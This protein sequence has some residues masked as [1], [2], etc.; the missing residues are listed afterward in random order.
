MGGR[1]ELGSGARDC[2]GDA[3]SG[4]SDGGS[5]IPM[6]GKPRGRS[7]GG[8]SPPRADAPTSAAA[9]LGGPP[10]D[11]V[12]R[13]MDGARLAGRSSRA[14]PWG[15]DARI[16]ELLRIRAESRGRWG[17]GEGGGAEA[18]RSSRP[19]IAGAKACPLRSPSSSAVGPSRRTGD[20]PEGCGGWECWTPEHPTLKRSARR[21]SRR[22]RSS[23]RIARTRTGR[24]PDILAGSRSGHRG[25]YPTRPARSSPRSASR[26]GDPR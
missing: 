2:A 13:G 19:R 3:G 15:L 22:I 4:V 9:G 18:W 5:K 7:G 26:T 25:G 14:R 23:R 10:E 16:S 1:E 6:A 8:V 12:G 17:A 24:A 21:A 20:R 11:P